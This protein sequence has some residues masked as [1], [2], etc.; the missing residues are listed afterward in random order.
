MKKLATVL[1][2]LALLL[3]CAPALAQKTKSNMTSEINTNLPDNI[4]GAITPAILRG[5]LNDMVNSYQQFAGVNAQSSN[6]YTVQASDYGQLITLANTNPIA[7]SVPQASTFGTAFSF[8]AINNGAGTATFTGTVSTVCGGASFALTTGQGVWII[9][10]GANY[11]CLGPFG[12]G[13]GGGPTGS[14]TITGGT[15]SRSDVARWVDAGISATDVGVDCTGSTD[16]TTAIQNFYTSNANGILKFPQNCVALV[17]STITIN[18]GAGTGL[19]GPLDAGNGAG[20]A[21]QILWNGNS[22]TG[23]FSFNSTDHPIVQGISFGVNGANTTG[24]PCPTYFLQFDGN[25][26]PHTGT[27]ARVRNNA[28]SGGFC[29]QANLIA[30]SI[31]PTSLTNQEN[32]IVDNNTVNCGKGGTGAGVIAT[33]GVTNGT[34]TV[35]SASAPF[36][37]GMAANTITAGSY[38]GGNMNFTTSGPVTGLAGTVVHISGVNPSAYNGDFFVSSASGTTLSISVNNL[39]PYVSGGTV[40]GMRMRVSYAGGTVDTNVATFTSTSSVVMAATIP[41]T[42]T[43]VQI[44]AG[45]FGYGIGIRNG[46]SQNAIQQQ[47]L[48]NVYTNCAI[49]IQVNGGNVEVKQP[50]GGFSDIGIFLGVSIAQNMLVD[51]YASEN[52]FEGLVIQAGITSPITVSNSR[53]SN[54]VQRSSGHVTLGSQV[55]F[56]NNL[57]NFAVG[58]NQVLLNKSTG[59]PQVISINNNYNNSY[60]GTGFAAFINPQIISINDAMG[61]TGAPGVQMFGCYLQPVPC[62]NSTVTMPNAGGTNLDLFTTGSGVNTGVAYGA[63]VRGNITAMSTYGTIRAE[64]SS[65]RMANSQTMLEAGWD[66]GPIDVTGGMSAGY[67]L[68]ARTP[69]SI[70]GGTLANLYGVQIDQQTISGVTNGWGVSQT[71]A[72]DKNLFAGSTQIGSNTLRPAASVPTNNA[73]TGFALSTGS[74]DTAGR[75]TFTSATSCAINFSAAYTNAPFCTVMPGSAASTVTVTTSTTVLTATFGTAQT[76]MQYHCLGT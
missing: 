33:N 48:T 47:F 15:T 51:Y 67:G 12:A 50:S 31:S 65:G 76:A 28:F 75:V 5:V 11:Q 45:S 13:G 27:A 14:Y 36:F 37:A 40:A 9:S 63:R 57:F 68:R 6:S 7:V 22:T 34:T 30:V 64:Q 56:Q 55:V 49:G 26:G 66:S 18:S 54:G 53:F 32:Y 46:S 25:A 72:G 58:T 62:L 60:A 42:Q 69:A 29:R 1:A 71:A 16:S 4:I 39:G 3:A 59:N 2:A 24:Y 74:N 70:A 73:C 52:D 20:N 35:T 61:F 10:D 8:A 21:P 38:S 41:F 19:I 44:M 43:N 23:M 17:S